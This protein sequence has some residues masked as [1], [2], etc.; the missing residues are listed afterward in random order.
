MIQ[1]PDLPLWAAILVALLILVGAAVTLIGSVGLL[2]L[3]S[4]YDRVH[5]PTLGTSLGTLLICLGSIVCFS[6]LHSR[7]V[8]HEILIMAF[9]T[10]T[11]PV[12]FMLLG[13]AAL[14]RD[15]TEGNAGVPPQAQ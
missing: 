1:A 14:Y 15:R 9:V 12:S 7:P 10:L 3:K 6:A 4:F 11:T 8:V 2:R 5:A 13:R